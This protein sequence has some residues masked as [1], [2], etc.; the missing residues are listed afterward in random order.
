MAD[1][2]REHAEHTAI[3]LTQTEPAA[4]NARRRR[5]GAATDPAAREHQASSLHPSVQPAGHTASASSGARRDPP[6]PQ[7]VLLMAC[8]LLRLMVHDL[9]SLRSIPAAQRL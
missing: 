1:A 3:R 9:R 4:N 5:A 6:N 8:E 7:A 2:H